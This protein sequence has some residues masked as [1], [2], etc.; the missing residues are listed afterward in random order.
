MLQ[1]EDVAGVLLNDGKMAAA[2]REM[3]GASLFSSA[4]DEDGLLDRL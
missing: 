2:V 4:S 1:Q 3:G